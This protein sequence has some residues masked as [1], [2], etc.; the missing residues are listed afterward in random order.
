ML[1]RVARISEFQ[2]IAIAVLL[3][4][5]PG[6]STLRDPGFENAPTGVSYHVGT[7]NGIS[8]V[9]VEAADSG[10]ILWQIEGGRFERF[11]YGKCP[12]Q[13]REVVAP[14]PLKAGDKVIVQV[15]Y[16]YDTWYAA[17]VGRIRSEFE[18]VSSNAFKRITP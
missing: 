10:K 4:P 16:Q 2:I 14:Q 8:R 1:A 18:V 15:N 3:G 17:S 13:T 9:T 11:D 6:C 5:S 7:Y 12:E